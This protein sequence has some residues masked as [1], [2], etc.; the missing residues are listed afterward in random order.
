MVGADVITSR[1]EP[2]RAE[3]SRAEPS[4]AEPSRAEPSRAEPSRAEPSRAEPSR[5]EPSRAEPSRAEPSRAEPSRAETSRAMPPRAGPVPNSR[6][7]TRG[8]GRSADFDRSSV[9]APTRPPDRRGRIA[10]AVPRAPRDAALSSSLRFAGS[11]SRASG[12]SA[13]AAV[14]AL[15]LERR[16]GRGARRVPRAS[17][18]SLSPWFGS[19]L[20]TAMPL[21]PGPWQITVHWTPAR[22]G[23][24]RFALGLSLRANP[25]ANF[26]GFTYLGASG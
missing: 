9:A 2:S 25:E 19:G 14:I 5:A 8:A 4:R 3:P 23:R 20:P 22:P 18:N 7:T 6:A 21:R 11:G 12:A 15:L 26:A 13:C 24:P 16:G 17:W 10:S 1:A